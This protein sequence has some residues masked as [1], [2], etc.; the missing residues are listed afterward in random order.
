MVTFVRVGALAAALGVTRQ[1]LSAWVRA[2]K[3]E[4]PSGAPGEVR[5]WPVAVAIEIL[6]SRRCPVPAAWTAE[7]VEQAA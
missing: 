4:A 7:K 2:A 3:I 5:R 6:T 1:T